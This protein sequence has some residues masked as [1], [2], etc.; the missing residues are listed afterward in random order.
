LNKHFLYAFLALVNLLFLQR[1][2]AVTNGRLT[3]PLEHPWLVKIDTC[4]GVI[5]GPRL[6]LT[7]AHC[8]AEKT[9]GLVTLKTN[10]GNRLPRSREIVVHPHYE[11]WSIDTIKRND[12]ALI[13]T[14]SKIETNELVSI[15][16]IKPLGQP[17]TK[18]ELAGWGKREDSSYPRVPYIIENLWSLPGPSSSFWEDTRHSFYLASDTNDQDFM[19]SFYAGGFL[20]IAVNSDS[21]QSACRG[22]SGAPLIESQTNMVVGI[23]SHGQQDCA[24]QASFFATHISTYSKW[25]QSVLHD[26]GALK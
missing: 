25:I 13:I 5:I 19:G 2:L 15:A 9:V 3:D 4:A 18:L 26:R 17:I 24:Y 6:I 23:V 12:I 10:D 22:D 16:K 14:S 8:V 20:A 21:A 11:S 7:A 1:G